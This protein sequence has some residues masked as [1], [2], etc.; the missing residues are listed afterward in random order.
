MPSNTKMVKVDI[1]HRSSPIKPS[2]GHSAR[3]TK[4]SPQK[5]PSSVTLPPGLRLRT[6]NLL[7]AFVNH[8][9]ATSLWITTINTNQNS[10]SIT[11]ASKYLKAFSFRTEREARESAYINAPPKM[12]PFESS[13]HCF[14]CEIKFSSVFRR[15]AHCRN[16]GVCICNSCSTTW[17]RLMVPDTYK[18]KNSKVKIVKVCKTCDYLATSFRHALLEGNYNQAISFYMTGNINLRCPFFNVKNGNEIMLP[19]HCAASGGNRKLL[20]WL[21]DVHHCPLKM[22]N[23]S[24]RTTQGT[25]QLIKT[26]HGRTVVDIA[27]QDKHVDILQYLVN[28]KKI[29]VSSDGTK[30]ASLIALEAVLKACATTPQ[31][32]SIQKSSSSTEKSKVK[33]PRKRSNEKHNEISKVAVVEAAPLY[34]IPNAYVVDDDSEQDESSDMDESDDENVI[35]NVES[36]DDQSVATTVKDACVI[37]YENSI[38]CVLTPCGHQICCLRCSHSMSIC[39]FC[40]APCSAIRIFKP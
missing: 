25:M 40:S 20:S 24:N 7:T 9:R 36:N 13:P 8:N 23:T 29:P 5:Q 14:N 19:I 2:P 11:K 10:N 34:N 26:S 22:T 1:S 37:C 15:P 4:V 38:D 6:R 30:D 16:C 3:K 21:V 18:T 32:D 39:P 35:N 17:G 28:K 27:I 31:K 12:L 33:V